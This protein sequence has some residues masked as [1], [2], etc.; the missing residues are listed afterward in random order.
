M[1][2]ALI[3]TIDLPHI[4][5]NLDIGH[6]KLGTAPLEDWIRE[7]KDHIAYIHLHSNNGIH[8]Q[9]VKAPPGEIDTLYQLLDQYAINPAIALEYPIQDLDEEI[10]AILAD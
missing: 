4:K 8:D 6:S 3:E 7:L 1:L 10:R 2:K 5:I 9:H